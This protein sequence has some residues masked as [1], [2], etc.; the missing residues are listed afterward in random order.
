MRDSFHHENKPPCLSVC[1]E[2]TATTGTPSNTAG[3]LIPTLVTGRQWASHSIIQPTGETYPGLPTSS[4]L[5]RRRA[6]PC[7]PGVAAMLT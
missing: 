2:H 1:L 5:T 6:L 4:T 7:S 3:L